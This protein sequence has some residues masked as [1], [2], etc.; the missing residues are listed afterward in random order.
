MK[1]FIF[2]SFL[3]LY[4]FSCY[5]TIE[6]D[7]S[8][9]YVIE[10]DLFNN[11]GVPVSGIPISAVANNSNYNEFAVVQTAVSDK[12]GHFQLIF[13]KVSG[14]LKLHINNYDYYHFDESQDASQINDMYSLKNIYF[15]LNDFTDY[16]LTIEEN[17]VMK[18]AT[19]LHVSYNPGTIQS[20]YYFIYTE[21]DYQY[22]NEVIPYN[23]FEYTKF[24]PAS[25]TFNVP[26]YSLVKIFD[27]TYDT[28]YTIAIEDVPV[29][30]V[31]PK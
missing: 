11:K 31:F 30:F 25:K 2:C 18:V 5:D 16:K 9:K 22:D 1:Y 20:K 24:Y 12:E 19:Q 3:I 10:G 27:S 23:N 8:E 28:T 29:D 15:S 21:E 13:S 6:F 14:N 26:K 17:N 7:A 4:G